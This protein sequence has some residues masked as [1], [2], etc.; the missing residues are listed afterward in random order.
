MAGKGPLFWGKRGV[1]FFFLAVAPGVAFSSALIVYPNPM[2]FQ[3]S[4]PNNNLCSGLVGGCVKFGSVPAGSS[5]KIYSASLAL[6]RVFL[7]SDSNFLPSSNPNLGTFVWDGNN[8][9][10]NPVSPGFYIYV[11]DGPAGR[12]FGKL[13]ISRSRMAP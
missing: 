11:M 5:L 7:P 8:G 6:V 13:A 1:L 2:D 3:H 10:G 9:D 4:P 12:A